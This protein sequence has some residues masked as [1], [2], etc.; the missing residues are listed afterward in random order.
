MIFFNPYLF[1]KIPYNGYITSNLIG[2]WDFGLPSSYYGANALVIHDLSGNGLDMTYALT[3]SYYPPPYTSNGYGVSVQVGGPSGASSTQNGYIANVAYTQTFSSTGFTFESALT[4]T[5]IYTSGNQNQGVCITNGG[6]S[7]FTYTSIAYGGG[8][9]LDTFNSPTE[10]FTSYYTN[11]VPIA[12]QMVHLTA[13][14][15]SS[16]AYNIYINGTL[17]GSGTG[18]VFPNSVTPSFLTL[19]SCQYA[20]YSQASLVNA[21]RVY[22][23]PLSAANVWT[24][25]GNVYQNL[26]YKTYTPTAPS[27]KTYVT[28][29]LL[30]YWDFTNSTS[31]PGSG[32]AVT[33]LSGNNIGLT[34]SG[35]PSFNSTG[36]LSYN[37]SST[38]YA[39]SSAVGLNL[40]SG[41]TLESLVYFTSLSNTP[42]TMGYTPSSGTSYLL[43][44]ITTSG[45]F[46]SVGGGSYSGNFA[47]A[48]GVVTT[49]QWYHL[50]SV[51]SSTTYTTCINYI[52][53]VAISNASGANFTAFPNNPASTQIYLGNVPFISSQYTNGKIAMGRIYNTALTA[54]Q[55]QENYVS[56]FSKL[57]GT[58]PYVM[59]GLLGYWDLADSR[60]SSLAGSALN[61]LGPVGSNLSISGTPSY[62]SSGALSFNGNGSNLASTPSTVSLNLTNG[63]TFEVLINLTATGTNQVISYGNSSSGSVSIQMNSTSIAANS[64]GY[65]GYAAANYTAP[66]GQ[67]LH[68]T[69]VFNTLTYTTA[70]I[71]VNGVSYPI[72]GGANFTSFPNNPAGYYLSVG[73]IYGSGTTTGINGKF[74]M[75]RIYGIPLSAS[76]VRQNYSA[77]FSKLASNPYVLPP[78]LNLNLAFPPALNFPVSSSSTVNLGYVSETAQSY[79]NG[80]YICICS[81]N[82]GSTRGASTAF[83]PSSNPSFIS[84]FSNSLNQNYLTTSPFTES[85]STSNAAINGIYGE[86]V[87]AT[88]PVQ[89][90]PTGF[91]FYTCNIYTPTQF[92]IFGSNVNAD[93]Y[94]SSVV[95]LMQASNGISDVSSYGATLT[96]QGGVSVSSVQSKFG[97]SSFYFNGSS[98]IFTPTTSTYNFGT[99]NF[100]IEM[101]AYPGSGLWGVAGNGG[102]GNGG[103]GN[104]TYWTCGIWTN[105][106]NQFI[107][108]G[109]GEADYT[110]AQAANSWVHVAYVRNG[111]VISVYQNG[112]QDTTHTVT[113]TNPITTLSTNYI[114]IGVD[115]KSGNV[116]AGFQGYLDQIRVTIGVC[117]YTSNFTAPTSPFP[118]VGWATLGSFGPI[119]QPNIV[120]TFQYYQLPSTTTSYNTLVML[121]TAGNSGTQVGVMGL[122]FYGTPVS[123]LAVP[124][125][126]PYWTS[127]AQYTTTNLIGYWDTALTASS[128]GTGSRI[129]YDL[130]GNGNNM[131]LS[132]APTYTTSPPSFIV[133]SAPN[134]CNTYVTSSSIPGITMEILI[135]LNGIAFSGVRMFNI[136]TNA[137]PTGVTLTITSTGSAV[138]SAVY[139][140]TSG[141]L[142]GTL[143]TPSQI[144]ATGWV[145]LVFALTSGSTTSCYIN[146]IASTVTISSVAGASNFTLGTEW[147]LG[148]NQYNDTGVP[149]ASIAM[150]RVYSTSLTYVQVY[151]NYLHCI[152]KVSGNPYGLYPYGLLTVTGGTITPVMINNVN[153][154]V[155]KFTVNDT[156]TITGGSGSL[157]CDVLIVAGGGSGG[158]GLSGSAAGGGGAGG[159]LC[160]STTLGG[161]S[162][163][164]LVI[165][166]GSYAVTVGAGGAAGNGSNGND[167]VFGSY[168]SKAGGAGGGALSNNSNSGG[169]ANIGGNGG[170]GGGSSQTS[171][172]GNGTAGQGSNGGISGG[173]FGAGGGGGGGAAAGGNGSGSNGGS[174]GS[175]GAGYLYNIDGTNT[176]YAGGGGGGGAN[177]SGVLTYAASGG[178]GGGGRGGDP[179]NGG[180]IQGTDGTGGGGGGGKGGSSNN[181]AAG[182]KGI[183]IVRYAY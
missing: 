128:S 71:Y 20:G 123:S 153:Y 95:L 31:Y 119:T 4:P 149:G 1:S 160:Y 68:V 5:S 101:W 117:R 142:T 161:H 42:V 19:G 76:Q 23:A 73:S 55:V 111:N 13:T 168:T 3:G 151:Q 79:G 30:G 34:I 169:N 51:F 146:S 94:F 10:N 43:Q 44:V 87:G 62:N 148:H 9:F 38:S 132:T 170:S 96:N 90:I 83:G 127:N 133:S 16:G 131:V 145:H 66:L 40:S 159:I 130:S 25:Y 65:G 138:T 183:V 156:F 14:V 56:A 164:A 110:P 72:T 121:V 92:S 157:T 122:Q 54:A 166:N 126:L 57:T 165:N 181:G 125:G 27:Y 63:F 89:I 67:W 140:G 105:G 167:S 26:T 86:W 178:N 59:T 64:I 61:D 74:A 107:G 135:N 22:N 155:H 78:P 17:I 171:T 47:T 70:S 85:N 52:N 93:P 104:N 50:V 75:G 139:S 108:T 180:A 109:S 129:L 21:A 18:Y 99:Q 28:S 60:S 175:G 172:S 173:T 134:T 115:G 82:G 88:L 163:T 91:S 182:G 41:C 53:G 6:I 158:S 103:P 48:A 49:G 81:S 154:K 179:V 8:W 124:P 98:N 147:E 144:P 24:N 113:T 118:N 84:W 15:N 174:A 120:G 152:N 7:P 106:A 97:T 69:C 35:T 177:I 39:A 80:Q 11:P 33:D 136:G 36:A 137:N 141:N 46:Q 45:S 116:R 176:S 162:G 29:N 37:P 102:Y 2:Y 58:V 100:T 150:A 12:N 77:A 114:I 112:V 32:A 143:T